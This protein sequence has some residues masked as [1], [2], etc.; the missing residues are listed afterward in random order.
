MVGIGAGSRGL[1]TYR[2][3]T[4]LAGLLGAPPVQFPGDHGGFMEQPAEFAEVLRTVLAGGPARG[5]GVMP[6]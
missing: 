5:P 1:V 2:T 4:A 3:S 6:R